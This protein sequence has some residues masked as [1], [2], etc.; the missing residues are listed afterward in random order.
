MATLKLVAERAGVSVAAVSVALGG[1]SSTIGVSEQTRERIRRVARE[2]KYRPN[3]LAASLRTGKTRTIGVYVPNRERY[4]SHPQG[5]RNFW[6]ICDA[7]ARRGYHV[8]II[9]PTDQ[10]MD[11]R[12]MDGCLS[13]DE[14]DP[15]VADRMA[16]LAGVIPVVS[17]APSIPGAIPVHQ[18]RSWHA[19]RRRAAGYLYELG[20]RNVAVI[21]TRER[22]LSSQGRIPVQFREEAEARGLSVE[23]QEYVED[24][25]DRRY[26][27]L[28]QILS[29][30]HRPTAVFAMDDDYARALVS[31]LLYEGLRVPQDISVFSGSTAAEPNGM[32][33][34]L[35]GLVLRFEQELR[36]LLDKFVDALEQGS[37]PKEIHLSELDVELV[38]RASCAPPLA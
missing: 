9:M 21:R 28:D 8:S 32:V 12:L 19:W 25:L 35:T 31:R 10:R 17:M 14:V 37:P 22:E 5:A 24:P 11:A 13:M 29:A 27:T 26:P 30:R 3:P 18:D 23:V 7:A 33:P 20:H 15:S 38:E 1:K 36:E 6:V 34:G 4:L 2:V 16:E